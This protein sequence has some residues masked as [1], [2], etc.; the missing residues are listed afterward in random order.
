M[1]HL[2]SRSWDALSEFAQAGKEFECVSG[3]A[4]VALPTQNQDQVVP[5]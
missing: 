3:E 1:I 2:C 4:L 5:H